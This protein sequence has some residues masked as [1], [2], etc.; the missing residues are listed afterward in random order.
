MTTWRRAC[1]SNGCVEVAYV[2]ACDTGA[3]VEVLNDGDRV[4]VRSSLK[5]EGVADITRD[6]WVVFLDGVKRGEFDVD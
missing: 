2:A 4:L 1:D 5:P 3:C 6:E